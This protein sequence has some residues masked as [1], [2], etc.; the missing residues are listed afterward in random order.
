MLILLVIPPWGLDTTHPGLMNR[1]AGATMPGGVTHIAAALRRRGHSVEIL[2]GYLSSYDEIVGS[3]RC[4]QHD[5][6]GVSC[7]CESWSDSEEFIRQIRSDIDRKLLIVAGGQGPSGLKERCFEELP[8]LDAI[9]VGEGEESFCQLADQV[10]QKD[11]WGD[12]PGLIFR[13]GKEVLSGPEPRLVGDLDALPFP[14]IDLIPLQ[15]Y[16]PSAAHYRRLP[17]ATISSSRGCRNN[18]LFCYK[19]SGNTLRM[20]SPA[21]VVAE[22]VRDYRE[23]GAG[24]IIFWDENFTHDRD[25]VLEICDRLR[26]AGNPVI[27][28][29]AGRA[30][31]V[32]LELLRA[33]KKAGCWQIL[34]GVESGN[35]RLLKVVR[36]NT[37]R[38][39]LARA[40]ES[41]HRAGLKTYGTFMIGLPTETY[42]DVLET[43]RF[44]RELGP[45]IAEFFPVTPFYGTEL[46]RRA[47]EFGEVIGDSSRLGMHL[48]PFVPHTMT[49]EE[50]HELRRLAHHGFYMRPS[51]VL[52]YL[53]RI[54][55]W[56]E[57]KDMF[58]GALA[59]LMDRPVG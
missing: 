56:T 7:V 55:S 51:Y 37:D 11:R 47:E 59:L 20:R 12:I 3:L 17:V 57:V 24:G 22:V 36:K 52:K 44:A 43:I 42:D 53:S 25:R 13:Q 38:E 27:W 29:C 45:D 6:L 32:D 46:E 41:A 31:S 16:V 14:A 21:N 1:V 35:E 2:D 30:D 40:F 5:I 54:R 23:F 48:A 58:K 28:W 4:G 9:V 26:S 10:D 39:V 18:C 19:I 34:F 49:L 33:M 50:I 15:A 8:E